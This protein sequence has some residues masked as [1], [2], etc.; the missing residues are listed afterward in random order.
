MNKPLQNKFLQGLVV[1]VAAKAL[2][3]SAYLSPSCAHSF[4][5][6][7]HDFGDVADRRF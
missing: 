6:F 7:L 1:G 4:D 5:L 3:A 2:G